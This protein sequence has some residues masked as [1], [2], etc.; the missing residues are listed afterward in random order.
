MQ[1][2]YDKDG[3]IQIYA[4]YSRRYMPSLLDIFPE[5][6]ETGKLLEWSKQGTDVRRDFNIQSKSTL[7][8]RLFKEFLFFLLDKVADGNTILLFGNTGSYIALQ[9]TP[10]AEVRRMRQ[11]GKYADYD[12]IRANFKI[13]RFIFDFGPRKKRDP[14]Q[15][16]PGKKLQKKALRNAE[17]GKLT[18]VEYRKL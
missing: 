3:N 11:M 2:G 7:I 5:D 17:E 8:R 4:R 15:I 1:Y 12:I 9:S 18:Y 13:P 10:D 6:R 14:A 16:Y